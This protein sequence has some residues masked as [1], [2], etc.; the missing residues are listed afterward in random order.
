MK[1]PNKIQAERLKDRRD[2]RVALIHRRNVQ[3]ARITA[4]EAQIKKLTD[5]LPEAG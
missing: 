3:D 5:G 4:V 1:T 2:L